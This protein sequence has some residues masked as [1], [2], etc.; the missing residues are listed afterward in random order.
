MMLLP[1][2][3]SGETFIGN[4]PA[5]LAIDLYNIRVPVASTVINPTQELFAL[6]SWLKIPIF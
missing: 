5:L 4:G 6:V 3:I 2:S 1:L